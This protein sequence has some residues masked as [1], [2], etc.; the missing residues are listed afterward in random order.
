MSD[1][2]PTLPV[3]HPAA[4]TSVDWAP[5]ECPICLQQIKKP[6]KARTLYGLR[7]CNKCR[8]GFANRRQLAFLVDGC[9][10]SLAY[11]ALSSLSA[12]L[13]PSGARLTPEY[14][15]LEEA[16]AWIGFPLLFS[17]RDAIHGISP[18]KV[19]TK[20]QVVDE[21]SREPIGAVQS[22]LRNVIFL[23]PY[24]GIIVGSSTMMKGKRWGDGWAKT[25]VVWLTYRH[26]PPFAPAGRYCRECGYDLTGNLSGQCPE[27]GKEIPRSVER[28]ASFA[29]SPST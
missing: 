9:I 27:C 5:G 28:N 2:P 22:F 3:A 4:D 13:A 16:I 20:V 21:R 11:H 18:G 26:R 17:F 14:A 6:Q 12:W 7:V 15:L 29:P 19:L 23:I 10:C 25:R 8:N 1:T 24:L